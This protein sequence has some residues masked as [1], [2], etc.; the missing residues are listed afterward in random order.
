MAKK[1]TPKSAPLL[2]PASKRP[3]DA[4]SI[5]IQIKPEGWRAVRDLALDLNTSV[6]KLGVEAF[7]DLLARHGRKAKVESAWD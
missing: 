6:Q 1:S 3:A 2:A 7:N 4:K 5:A